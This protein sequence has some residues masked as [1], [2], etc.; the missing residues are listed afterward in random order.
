MS[1]TFD[2]LAGE[3]FQRFHE[4]QCNPNPAEIWMNYKFRDFGTMGLVGRC[5]AVEM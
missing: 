3:G 4:F 1:A 5:V 2:P